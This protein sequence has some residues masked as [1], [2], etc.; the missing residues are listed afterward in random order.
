HIRHHAD[1][2]RRLGDHVQRQLHGL[3]GGGTLAGAT[4]VLR[5]GAVY[6][7]DAVGP[8]EAYGMGVLAHDAV[9]AHPLAF[10]LLQRCMQRMQAVAGDPFGARV[11]ADD[12]HGADSWL[13]GECLGKGF[14]TGESVVWACPLSPRPLPRGE[15]GLFCVGLGRGVRLMP[16][17]RWRAVGTGSWAAS[18]PSPLPSWERVRDRGLCCV[19]LGRGARLMPGGRW[20]A[21]GTGSRAASA[22]SPLAPRG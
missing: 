12:G 19:V 6:A 5:A 7:L 3:D 16:G 21:E 20:R 15:R 22:P 14:R 2:V 11:A 8:D 17:T 9:G 1:V 13:D 18:S 4:A 10:A